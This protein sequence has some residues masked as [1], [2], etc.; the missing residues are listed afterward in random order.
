MVV[1][2]DNFG[3]WDIG[4]PEERAFFDHVQRH[5]VPIACERCEQPVRLMEEPMRLLCLSA[6]IWS[7]G[8]NERIWLQPKTAFGSYSSDVRVA[9][10]PTSALC[11]RRGDGKM[12]ELRLKGVRRSDPKIIA[13]DPDLA[14][15]NKDLEA[16]NDA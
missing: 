6:R 14:A 10:I 5:S 3:F 11:A 15:I 16:L 12:S 13:S 1:Y 9:S 8:F 2:D 7:A 4:G